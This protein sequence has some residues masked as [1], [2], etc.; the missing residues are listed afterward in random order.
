VST[1]R[2]VVIG[3]DAGGMT[4]ASQARRRADPDELEIVAFERGDY[5][6]YSAC[7][8]PYFVGGLVSDV[9]DLIAR[10]PAEHR[11]NGI[12]VRTRTEVIAIDLAAG[13]VTARELDTGGTVTETFDDL[14]IST[15]ATPRRPTLPGVDAAGVHGVQTLTDG[16]RLRD[17]VVSAGAA[18]GPVV[19]VGGGYVG[20]ELA[21]ALHRR[22]RAVTVIEAGVQPMSA[23][24]PDMGAL[25]ARAI[26][27][28]GIT[29]LTETR[30]DAFE[31]DPTGH[32]RAV[33]VGDR[34]IAADMVVLGLGVTPNVELAR[35]AGIEI[36]PSGG[37][38]TSDTMATSAAHVW[39]AGDCVECHHRVSNRPVVVALGTHANKQGRV[40]GVN[41]TGGDARFAGVLGTAATNICEY[42]IARTGLN[43]R[44]ARDAGFDVETATIESTSHAGYYPQ[45][46]SL[47]VKFVV[48]R[49]GRL[50]GG[51]IIGREGAAKRIDVLAT[52]IWN[53]MTV[54]EVQQLDL[55]Y[56]PPFSTVWDPVLIAARKATDDGSATRRP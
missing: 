41:V 3:G 49:G 5:T 7:G 46:T 2:L 15:G 14:V 26:R 25:V 8:I 20:L 6:S 52:A 54:E 40:V 9:D 30:V 23:L 50:L 17:E 36:G 53:E 51:Q 18:N 29:L 55:A 13:A 37:I 10:S 33:T 47:T 16:V 56:A 44:E 28:L 19:V 38:A 1:R 32:V 39:A 43:E 48:E 24:D 12:D 31:T 21:E 22:G 34:T 45:A 4:A 35:A 27:G 42:E 11:G